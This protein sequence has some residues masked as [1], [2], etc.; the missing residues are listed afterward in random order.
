M[1]QISVDDIAG[2]DANAAPPNFQAKVRC[3]ALFVRGPDRGLCLEDHV[4]L[5]ENV[6]D[7]AGRFRERL[8]RERDGQIN[9]R[10]WTWLTLV[11]EPH[12]IAVLP[13]DEAEAIPAAAHR[14]RAV[15]PS[16]EFFIDA[17]RR[18]NLPPPATGSF[19]G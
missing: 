13:I 3:S 15:A 4:S 18:Q 8:A 6:V 2:S 14:A 11:A 5:S 10:S 1:S 19:L 7:G 16:Q 9:C 12:P 17:E